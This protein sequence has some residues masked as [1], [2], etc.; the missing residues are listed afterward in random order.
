ME[1]AIESD[2]DRARRVRCDRIG[3]GVRFGGLLRFVARHEPGCKLAQPFGVDP[4]GTGDVVEREIEWRR[5][6][7]VG[8]RLVPVPRGVRGG[9]DLVHDGPA[10]GLEGGERIV[11]VVDRAQGS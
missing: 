8:E 7:P 3:H 6:H 2:L 1:R 10:R 9:D 4:A 5:I 11:Q